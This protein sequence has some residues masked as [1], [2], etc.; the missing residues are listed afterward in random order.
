MVLDEELDTFRFAHL[1]VREF[2]ETR[3]EYSSCHA[4]ALAAEA[5]LFDM[6]MSTRKCSD[7]EFN[8]GVFPVLARYSAYFWPTHC[9]LAGSRRASGDL[10]RLFRSF[11][12]DE[13]SHINDWKTWLGA[14]ETF[15]YGFAVTQIRQADNWAAM[16]PCRVASAY[17][18]WEVI[19]E[20]MGGET[21]NTWLMN[22]DGET[23]L[24]IAAYS[25][26]YNS[27][28]SLLRLKTP[29]TQTIRILLSFAI[30]NSKTE[31]HKDTGLSS[32]ELLLDQFPE[33]K[34][35]DVEVTAATLDARDIG[36]IN[37]L[38]ARRGH[39]IEITERLIVE[40]A[41][42]CS[43]EIMR[44][45]LDH[46]S[47]EIELSRDLLVAAASNYRGGASILE[48]ILSR[49]PANASEIEVSEGVVVAAIGNESQRSEIFNLLLDARGI[50]I[51]MTN[52]LNIVARD[53]ISGYEHTKFLLNSYNNEIHVTE[54]VLMTA[55]GNRGN[56]VALLELLLSRSPNT[57]ITNNVLK[58]AASCGNDEVLNPLLSMK[59]TKDL[60]DEANKWIGISRLFQAALFSETAVVHQLIRDNIPLDT[61][62][63]YRTPLWL[64]SEAA[65]IEVVRLLLATN[66]VNV[67]YH[68]GDGLTPLFMATM[69]CHDEI[70]ELLL[71][72]GARKDITDADGRMLYSM[73]KS[74][75]GYS[76]RDAYDDLM[77][78]SPCSYGPIDI[79]KPLSLDSEYKVSTGT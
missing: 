66:A 26:I 19:D 46:R 40:T 76:V 10:Q 13:N 25:G 63:R 50:K 9:R 55:A 43:P 28:K 60:D 17:D 14:A 47:G 70:V 1:S 77:K 5:C 53:V 20:I 72:H 38:L 58:V 30:E 21:K 2:L 42:D 71:N 65:R 73:C 35:S 69:G 56:G 11:M 61:E 12:C 16:I 67:N 39:E 29:N 4:N 62:G 33:V 6:I 59:Y 57:S 48:A 74:S 24:K 3:P 23:C 68:S 34:I 79:V 36:A 15:G 44:L 31:S 49:R 51:N 7:L 75:P 78:N 27:L 8:P 37:L 52:V 64:A 41:L 32:M 45:L 54:A 18:L 22:S